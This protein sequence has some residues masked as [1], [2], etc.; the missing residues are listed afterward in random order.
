[1]DCRRWVEHPSVA[2]GHP[3]FPLLFPLTGGPCGPAAALLPEVAA[4]AARSRG[5]AALLVPT[6]E[7]AWLL[8]AGHDIGDGG[9]NAIS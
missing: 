2:Q 8:K 1:M 4:Q 3:P 6:I 9:L 5:P 7:K